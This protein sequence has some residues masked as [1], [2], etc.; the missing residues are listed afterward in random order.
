[1][2]PYV[3]LLAVLAA[4]MLLVCAALICMVLARALKRAQQQATQLRLALEAATVAASAQQQRLEAQF[5][6]QLESQLESQL[7]FQLKCQREV[8]LEYQRFAKMLS[9]EFRT[10]LATIDGALQNLDMTSGAATEATRLRYR[11]M[12]AALEQ[13]LALI[14]DYL[15]PQRMASIGRAVRST[16]LCPRELLE[17]ALAQHIAAHQSGPQQGGSQQGG[18]Q[19]GGAPRSITL[20]M[21]ALPASLRCEPDATRLCLQLLLDNA[22]VHT[23]PG[24]HIVLSARARLQGGIEIVVQ[25]DGP[26]VA[27]HDIAHVFDNG[28]R[29]SS[30]AGAQAAAGAGLG[31]YIARSIIE[32]QGGTL[33]LEN[34]AGGGVAFK[35]F[36]STVIAAEKSLASDT[37]NRDNSVHDKVIGLDA[38]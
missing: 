6:A 17:S 3:L 30:V 34:V 10:P 8:Q 24:S 11:K 37:C 4:A 19:Q 16:H 5:E 14:D 21:E 20:H 32:G 27:L 31:L 1:M 2:T 35:M 28:Y 7:D 12:A 25:D 15:S 23:P 9:H 13:L 26:G 38:R 36:L 22:A 33:T 29:G 18:I